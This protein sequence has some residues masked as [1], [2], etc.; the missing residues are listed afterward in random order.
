MAFFF[1]IRLYWHIYNRFFAIDLNITTMA[2]L[3]ENTL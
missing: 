1:Y 3:N 2:A